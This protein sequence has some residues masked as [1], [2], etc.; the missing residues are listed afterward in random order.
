MLDL[1]IKQRMN[2]TDIITDFPQNLLHY[3]ESMH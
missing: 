2:P 1:K 3:L